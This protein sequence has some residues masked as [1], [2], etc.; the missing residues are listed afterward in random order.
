MR[1]QAMVRYKVAFIGGG[2]N[3]IAGYVHFCAS[4]LD[5]LFEVSAGVFSRNKEINLKSADF[6]GADAFE[7]VDTM[8]KTVKGQI[9]LVVVLTPTP[10]HYEHVAKAIEMGYPVICEK[11]LFKSYEEIIAFEEKFRNSNYFLCITYNYIA[12]PML[13][14]LRNMFLSGEMGELISMHLEMPQ[15]SFLRPPKV[16]DYPPW[17]RKKDE[18]IPTIILDL[19]SHLFSISYYITEKDIKR[20]KSIHRSFSPYGVVDDVKCLFEYESG[21]PGFMW[22]SKVALGNRNGLRVCVYGTKMSAC[23]VQEEPEKLFVAKS[24]GEKLIIDRG[25]NIGISGVRIYNRMTPGH[26]A[27]FIE[28]FANLYSHIHSAYTIYKQTG[29]MQSEPIIWDFEKEKKNFQFMKKLSEDLLW[30]EK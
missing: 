9:D 26:P 5:G 7:D 14:E 3:S 29:K 13:T 10:L 17:W 15:E 11:P 24:N 21:E 8:L 30:K 25:S 23:W 6:Y 1:C 19:A 2:I 22:V 27:G 28:A 4:R 18:S 12:Y 20:L 16:I